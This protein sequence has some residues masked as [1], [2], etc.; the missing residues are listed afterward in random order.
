MDVKN[1]VNWAKANNL[2][3]NQWVKAT[4]NYSDNNKSLILN[5]ITQNY[6]RGFHIWRTIE[7]ARDYEDKY[8]CAI[9]KVMY[10]NILA[11]GKD[12]AYKNDC[13]ITEYMKIL[14]VSEK[15]CGYQ[16]L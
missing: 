7:G 14:S 16:K 5:S 9:A 1:R 4:G 3:V 10:K 13:I 12:G 6:P 11:F 2:K 8:N 15:Y